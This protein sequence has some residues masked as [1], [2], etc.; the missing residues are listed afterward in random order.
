MSGDVMTFDQTLVLASSPALQAPTD[1]TFVLG[2]HTVDYGL[3][4]SLWDMDNPAFFRPATE[5]HL[6]LTAGVGVGK[7]VLVRDLARQ[8]VE[9]MEVFLYDSWH[10]QKHAAIDVP[11]EV[12]G[13]A[14][15]SCTLRGAAEMLRTVRD[16]VSRRSRL[17]AGDREDLPRILVLLEDSHHLTL[18]ED[19]SHLFGGS[20]DKAA[21]VQASA[22]CLAMLAEIATAQSVN[23]TLVF[24][25]VKDPADAGVPEELLEASFTHVSLE[26]PFRNP[27]GDP[28]PDP[29][30]PRPGVLTRP[31]FGTGRI[32]I[33]YRPT[34]GDVATIPSCI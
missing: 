17:D 21:L 16:E 24:A 19:N 30:L 6:V 15:F 20:R 11:A 34:A 7:T 5:G 3:D 4:E 31:G 33:D 13:L 32:L 23:V 27:M 22:S 25:S 29:D 18:H 26:R 9:T 10:S 1:F 8:A 14:G 28:I 12:P 2:Q